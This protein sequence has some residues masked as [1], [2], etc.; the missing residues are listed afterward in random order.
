DVLQVAQYYVDHFTDPVTLNINVGYGE[1]GG[2][3]LNG[4]LGMSLS[5]LQSSTYTQIKTALSA[6]A[7][8]TDSADIS[9]VASLLGDPTSGGQYWLTTAEAKAVG[10]LTSTTNID[11]SVGF[12][13]SSGIF[14]YDNSNGVSSG[15]YDFTAV[16]AH[17]FSEVIGRLL[18]VGSTVGSTSNSY[19]VL[20]LFHY[21]GSGAHDLSGSVPGYFSVDNGTTNLHN[22]NFS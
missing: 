16:V 18:L 20:D 8:P 5:Y 21:S 11:G 12:S 7:N 1:A 9:A 6:D 13:S 2:N 17:E 14:D 15:Q 10:L 22:F 4:A 3:S 19:D